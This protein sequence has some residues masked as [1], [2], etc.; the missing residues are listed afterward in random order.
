MF[1]E[2][3]GEVVE[4][5]VSASNALASLD[6]CADVPV[7]RAVVKPPEDVATRAKVEDLRNRV[8]ELKA[9]FDAGRYREAVGM[10]RLWSPSTKARV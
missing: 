1:S 10:R 7:L 6:R 5:A 8:A 9:K 4:N 3:T 2:A